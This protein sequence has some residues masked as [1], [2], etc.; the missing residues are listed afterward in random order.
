MDRILFQLGLVARKLGVTTIQRGAVRH[1][2]TGINPDNSSQR[3][4]ETFRQNS[5]KKFPEPSIGG[6]KISLMA[7]VPVLP[8]PPSVA[9][10]LSKSCTHPSSE[11]IYY[12]SRSVFG[13][14]D[15]QKETLKYYQATGINVEN[16]KP[17]FTPSEHDLIALLAKHL[18]KNKQSAIMTVP[19]FG[20]FFNALE[21]NNVKVNLAK[22]TEENDWKLTPQI[23]RSIL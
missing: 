21:R 17:L 14:E 3:L 19:T 2:T 13:T 12:R 8:P 16:C 4:V 15:L 5:K 1:F 22:L 20:L 10:F 6:N 18:V 7:S 9:K 11:I 23:L